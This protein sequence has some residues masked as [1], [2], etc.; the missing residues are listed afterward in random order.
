[1]RGLAER[2]GMTLIA[3]KCYF[4]NNRAK[5]EIAV[6]RGKKKHDKRQSIKQKEGEREARIAMRRGRTG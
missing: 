5:L 6:A 1:V 3:T 2:D 4:K